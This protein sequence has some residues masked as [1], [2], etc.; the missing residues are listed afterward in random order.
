M[1]CGLLSDNHKHS[2][3]QR[4]HIEVLHFVFWLACELLSQVRVVF[5]V[6]WNGGTRYAVIAR[7]RVVVVGCRNFLRQVFLH[8]L[9]NSDPG[10]FLQKRV[11]SHVRSSLHLLATLRR[12]CHLSRV[13]FVSMF[14]SWFFGV[15]IYDLHF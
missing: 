3:Y 14:A 12:L 8:I 15:N 1:D 4:I 2:P 13:K 7:L 6:V 10:S 5:L 11:S 9:E